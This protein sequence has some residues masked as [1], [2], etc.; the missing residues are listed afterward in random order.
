MYKDGR[1]VAIPRVR[2]H[3]GSEMLSPPPRRAWRPALRSA[4]TARA[5]AR[6]QWPSSGAR[7]LRARR[8]GRAPGGALGDE[9]ERARLVLEAGRAE[10]FKEP[11]AKGRLMHSTQQYQV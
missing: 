1:Y 5:G 11:L 9:P 6:R 4:R 7:S 3:A 2:P 10:H 8:A